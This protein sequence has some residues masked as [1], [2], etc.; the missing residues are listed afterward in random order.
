MSRLQRPARFCW[1]SA[2]LRVTQLWL[3]GPL[4]THHRPFKPAG[5]ADDQLVERRVAV[6]T[7]SISDRDVTLFAF[8][9]P[10]VALPLSSLCRE[11]SCISLA[12]LLALHRRSP[13][14]VTVCIGQLELSE[15]RG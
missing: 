7:R 13:V 8:P 12:R 15:F 2:D 9:H 5:I 4:G 10:L 11:G 6:L 14:Q 3:T 1:L